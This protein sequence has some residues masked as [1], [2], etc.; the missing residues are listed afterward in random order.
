[1]GPDAQILRQIVLLDLDLDNLSI[2][3]RKKSFSVIKVN[4]FLRGDFSS[5]LKKKISLDKIASKVYKMWYDRA[6]FSVFLPN[7]VLGRAGYQKKIKNLIIKKGLNR[8]L[9]LLL[10]QCAG[11][12][13]ASRG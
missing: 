6:T 7:S 13:G 9:F 2:K 3:V 1:M 10:V 5:D 11:L 4:P 12:R 8:T